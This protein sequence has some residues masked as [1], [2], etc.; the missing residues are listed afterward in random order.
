MHIAIDCKNLAIPHGANAPMQSVHAKYMCAKHVL[1][2]ME[3]NRF[4]AWCV[5]GQPAPTVLFL[6]V[7]N[8]LELN[9]NTFIDAK[10][11]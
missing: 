8:K 6:I 5:G 2:Y 3:R 9:A 7:K 4:N 1:K 10:I 11:A